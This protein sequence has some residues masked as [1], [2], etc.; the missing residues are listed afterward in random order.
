MTDHHDHAAVFHRD[1]IF[2]VFEAVADAKNVDTSDLSPLTTVLDPHALQDLL[3]SAHNTTVTFRYDDC[4]VTIKSTGETTARHLPI[5]AIGQLSD[6]PNILLLGSPRS[7]AI[8][9]VCDELLTGEPNNHENT[10]I[11]EYPDAAHPSETHHQFHAP[12]DPSRTTLIS[13]GD[14][15][16]AT[17]NHPQA[18][19]E[20]PIATTIEY[21]DDP[22]ELADLGRAINHYLETWNNNNQ[23]S[24]LCFD[25]LAACLDAVDL[26]DAF[27]FIHLITARINSVDGTAHYH[28]DPTQVSDETIR[29]LEPV[30][31]AVVSISADGELT[32][33]SV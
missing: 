9:D 33:E 12:P 26:E 25:S 1:G 27:K 20:T 30:F 14:T 8:A 29:T 16:L 13:V 6:K 11:I 2:G 15:T 19:A 17:A 7:Q 24:V 10:L 32:V 28:L 31:D 18:P 21:V 4:R 22:S 5:N 23:Q 3:D